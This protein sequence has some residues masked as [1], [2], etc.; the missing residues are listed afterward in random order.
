[1]A[2]NVARLIRF[3]A[4]NPMTQAPPRPMPAAIADPATGTVDISGIIYKLEALHETYED[5][6]KQ[7]TEQLTNL[8]I[9]AQVL[10]SLHE[11]ATA[12]ARR[13]ISQAAE[14][15]QLMNGEVRA[16]IL[17][18]T[19]RRLEDSADF[20]DER[21]RSFLGAQAD[22]T[23]KAAVHE[24]L[25]SEGA[26][27]REWLEAS[28]DSHKAYLVRDLKTTSTEI[29]ETL[30]RDWGRRL[31]SLVDDRSHLKMALLTLMGDDMRAMARQILEEERTALSVD[32]D[33]RHE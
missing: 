21:M 23:V 22:Y 13:T 6:L 9:P 17:D 26:E 2:F 29:T 16:A 14:T 19:H 8:E 7:A 27:R 20:I 10:S 1:M 12:S 18:Y 32:A 5:V 15:G 4:F 28:L 24:V 30:H 33:S 11:T 31:G 25:A 3:F